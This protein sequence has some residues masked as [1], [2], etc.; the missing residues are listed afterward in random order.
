M[1]DGNMISWE[2]GK[3]TLV[4][5]CVKRKNTAKGI[6]ICQ[7]MSGSRPE[8]GRETPGSSWCDYFRQLLNLIHSNSG[9]AKGYGE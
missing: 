1:T 8:R 4:V 7:S 3:H 9:S 5:Q 2:A 6:T